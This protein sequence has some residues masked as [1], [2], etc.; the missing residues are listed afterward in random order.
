MQGQSQAPIILNVIADKL[1]ELAEFF[2]LRIERAES[3]SS[4]I[5]EA[6][7]SLATTAILTVN[8]SDNPHGVVQFQPGP[9]NT[10]SSEINPISITVIR[11]FGTIG[12]LWS[13]CYCQTIILLNYRGY[14]G[15]LPGIYPSA[16]LDNTG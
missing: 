16:I 3:V 7:L 15:H 12:K 1:P 8:A 9:T 14:Q 10:S 5:G 13:T 6:V 4:N 11:T 2:T